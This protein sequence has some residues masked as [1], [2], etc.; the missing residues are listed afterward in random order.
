MEFAIE[1]LKLKQFRKRFLTDR[2]IDVQTWERI[3]CKIEEVIAKILSNKLDWKKDPKGILQLEP[4]E[5]LMNLRAKYRIMP[6]E[7]SL[8]KTEESET[9]LDWIM[10]INIYKSPESMKRKAGS[11]LKVSSDDA[12]KLTNG[13]ADEDKD[14]M[15]INDSQQE[16]HSDGNDVFQIEKRAKIHEASTHTS[17]A[18]NTPKKEGTLD[19][20]LTKPQP[21]QKCASNPNITKRKKETKR[22]LSERSPAKRAPLEAIDPQQMARLE[23]FNEKQNQEELRQAA[24]KEELKDLE[25]LHCKEC[26]NDE[27]KEL[28][29]SRKDEILLFY[30][31][32]HNSRSKIAI[33]G[34]EIDSIIMTSSQVITSKQHMFIMREVEKLREEPVRSTKETISSDVV[35]PFLIIELFREVHGFSFEEAVD[36]IKSQVEKFDLFTAHLCDSF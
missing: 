29:K 36:R 2:Y 12:V 16:C 20:W 11:C 32:P 1:Q 31:K 13:N 3:M 23:E 9:S 27:L 33:Q 22:K 28:V 19:K 24:R 34:I 14:I 21:P 5:N 15:V 7:H 10:R 35:M 30:E 25:V 4:G 26:T 8:V 6:K 18:K 17:S